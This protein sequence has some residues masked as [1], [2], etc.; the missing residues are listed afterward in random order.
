MNDISIVRCLKEGDAPTIFISGHILHYAFDSI[1]VLAA[2][3]PR[4][5]VSGIETMTH[6]KYQEAFEQSTFCQYWIIDKAKECIF[7]EKT[8]TYSNVYGPYKREV[9]LTKRKELGVPD[10][11]KLKTE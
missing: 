7:D 10:K 9:Y 11:L 3:R 4:D 1:F 8:R 5:S 6:P 2:Q